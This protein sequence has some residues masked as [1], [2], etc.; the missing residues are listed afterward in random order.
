MEDYSKA[1]LDLSKHCSTEYVTGSR[2]VTHRP[3][4]LFKALVAPTTAGVATRAYLRNGETSSA[5]I[6]LDL[7]ANY[8]HPTHGDEFP[9]YFNKGLYVELNTNVIGVTVQ[10][11]TWPD[12]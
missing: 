7:A 10:Y 9:I 8:A 12:T 3:C 6:L 5:N 1:I 4:Y 2:R 11:Y